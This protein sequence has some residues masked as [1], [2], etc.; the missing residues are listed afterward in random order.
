MVTVCQFYS[1]L[2]HE[3]TLDLKITLEEQPAAISFVRSTFW[4]PRSVLQDI[5]QL[6]IPV[7]DVCYSYNKR[8]PFYLLVKPLQ[9]RIIIKFR[10]TECR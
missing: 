2:W 3:R 5:C 4:S 10:G 7:E 8:P 1:C 9:L 6:L